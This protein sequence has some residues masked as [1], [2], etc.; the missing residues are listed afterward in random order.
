MTIPANQLI[1]LAQIGKESKNHV[2]EGEENPG[3]M[4]NV[5][6]YFFIQCLKSASGQN[7]NN[8]NIYNTYSFA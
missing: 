8:F 7:M 6:K 4:C 2:V 1:S 5:I 3:K